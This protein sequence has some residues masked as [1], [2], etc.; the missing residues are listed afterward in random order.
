MTAT[1][2]Y[3]S[4]APV[5][6]SELLYQSQNFDTQSQPNFQKQQQQQRSYLDPA[7]AQHD[8]RIFTQGLAQNPSY[9]TSIAPYPA[10]DSSEGSMGMWGGVMNWVDRQNASIP[11][12][13]YLHT[14]PPPSTPLYVKT[15]SS[16]TQSLSPREPNAKRDA[17][18]AASARFRQK[19]KQREKSLEINVKEQKERIGM[20]ECRIKE[21]EGENGFLKEL[22]MGRIKWKEERE[23]EEANGEEKKKENG[24]GKTE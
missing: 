21:L 16:P 19:K 2:I 6:E 3:P 20:M 9:D 14:Q 18:T 4:T 1:Q 22:V 11:M 10:S 8:L 23:N 12:H 24:D 5:T 13:P 7:L 15:L 17:S